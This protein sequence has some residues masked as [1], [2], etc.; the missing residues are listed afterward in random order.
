MK[1]LNLIILSFLAVFILND[2]LAQT[3]STF[4]FAVPY[5]TPDHVGET[6]GVIRLT[7]IDRE[8]EVTVT[9]PTSGSVIYQGVIPPGQTKSIVLPT[10]Y[11]QNNLTNRFWDV[12][13]SSSI[14]IRAKSPTGDM[15]PEIKAY[16]EIARVD[17]SDTTVYSN[18]NNNPDIFSLKGKNALGDEFYVPFQTYW[19]NNDFSSPGGAYS[20]FLMVA[21]EDNTT[22]TVNSPYP[23][24]RNALNGGGNYPA[25]TNVTITLDRGES[26]KLT[27]QRESAGSDII[28]IDADHRLRGTHITSDKPIAVTTGDDSDRKEGAYDFV[29]DQL[30]PLENIENEPVI[31]YEY[32]VMR[33]QVD[34]DNGG[35]RFY[36]LATEDNTSFDVDIDAGGST[37]YNIPNAGEQQVVDVP[38][39]SEYAHVIADKPVYVFHVSGFG[40]EIGGAVLPTIDGC[41]GSLDVSFV[42]SKEGANGDEFYLN[43]MTKKEGIANFHVETGNGDTT[44]TLD[45]GNFSHVPGTDWYI[46]DQTDDNLFTDAEITPHTVTRVY[47]DSSVF[48]L[49]MINGRT[50]GGGCMYGYFSDYIDAEP[51]VVIVSTGSTIKSGCFGDTIQ[52]RATG[53]ISY[54]WE[55]SDYLDDPTIAEPRA[56]GLPPGL[57][58]YDAIINNPCFGIDTLSVLIEIYDNVDAHFEIN[59]GIGCAPFD[60]TINNK[61]TG[62]NE[63]KW[64]WEDDRDFDFTTNSDSTFVHSYRNRGASDSVFT[65]RLVALNDSTICID[66]YQR[67]VRVHP[68]IH[69][70]FDQ[71]TTVGCNP[72]EVSFTDTSRGNTHPD[73]YEWD[74]GDGA[75][76]SSDTTL[77][78]TFLNNRNTDTTFHVQLVT[79][80]P[81]LCRD[82]A[83]QDITV[84]SYLEANFT[85]D[86]IKGCS[87]LEVN[88]NHNSKGDVDSAFWSFTGTSGMSFNDTTYSRKASPPLTYFYDTASTQTDT[89]DIRLRVSNGHCYD[90]ITRRVYVYPEVTAAYSP[91]DVAGC[92]PLPVS[93]TNQS[94]YTGMATSDTAGLVYDWDFGDGGASSRYEPAHLFDNSN[95]ADT[96]YQVQLTVTS[97]HGCQDSTSSQI[98]VS[99]YVKADFKVEETNGCAPFEVAFENTS[100]GG[101]DSVYWDFDEDG[102]ADSTLTDPYFT[103]TFSN[104]GITPDT[105]RLRQIVENEDNCRDTVYRNIIVY[106]HVAADF[107]PLDTLACNPAE[108]AFRNQSEYVGT[109]DTTG[110]LYDWDFGDGSTSSLYEPQY[111]FAHTGDTTAVFPVSLRVANAYGCADTLVDRVRVHPFVEAD[112]TLSTGAG[113]SPL[114]VEVNNYSSGGNYR[115]FWDDHHIPAAD[116]TG[117]SSGFSK[118]FTNTDGTIDTLQLT[119]IAGNALGCTDTMKRRVVI[120]PEVTA[121]FSPMDALGCNP[122]EQT[123]DNL[124]AY[125]NTNDNNGL[126]YHWDFGD[127]LSTKDFEPTHTYLNTADT[128]ARFLTRLQTISPYNCRDTITDTVEVHPFIQADFEVDKNSGCSPLNISIT[129]NSTGG[130]TQYYW[131]WDHD[132]SLALADADSVTT[133]SGFPITYTNTSGSSQENNLTLV[134]SN[135]HCY[136]T[137]QRKITV[138]SSLNAHFTEDVTQGCNPLTVDFD[139]NNPTAGA[140]SWE[141]GD[142]A[143]S[144]REDPTHEFTNP[145]VHDTIY[146]VRYIASTPYGC[147]DTA[148]Q[149][150]TVYSNLRAD[151]E[152]A[153]DE[154]CPPYDVTFDN[155]SAGNL[156][157]TYQWSVDGAP[158]GGAP[159]DTSDFSHTFTNQDPTLRY[160]EVELRAENIQGCTSIY[161]DTITVYQD[162]DADFGMSRVEGCSPLQIGFSD[163]ASVPANTTY[164]WS[165]GDGATSSARQPS[166]TFTNYDRVNDTSYTINL[167]VISP[168]NCHHD[169]S[170]SINVYHQP[171]ARFDIDT[172]ASCPPLVATMENQS[173]G[174][175][176]FQWRFGDG[177][178]NT[179]D[180]VVTDYSYGGNNTNSVKNYNLGLYVES[181]RGCGDST[182]L[183]LNVYPEVIADFTMDNAA[184]CHPHPVA[185]T[186]NSQNADH[187]LWDFDDGSSSNQEDPI[188]R[189]VN[190]SGSDTAYDV[191]LISSSAFQCR[192]T[193]T[194]TVEVYAQP[195]AQF[196]A[197]PQLQKWPEN[198][199]FITNATNTGPWDYQWNFDDGQKDD[200]RSPNYHDY[201]MWGPYTIGLEVQ[202]STSHCMDTISK[203][204][205]LLPPRTYANFAMD[206]PD[207]C[208]PHEVSFTGGESPFANQTTETYEYSWD[209]GDGT[210]GEGRFPNH[211]YDSAGT[212]YVSMK[213]TGAGGSD[214]ATDTIQVYKVPEVDF[215]VDPKLV[216]L[217]DQVMH[218]FN[219]TDYAE[220]Y[221]WN[222]GDGSTSEKKNPEHVYEELGTYDVVLTAYKEYKGQDGVIHTCADSLSKEDLVQVEGKGFIKFPDAFTPNK[223]GPSEGYWD[224]ED[225]SNDIFHPVGEG[226]VEY[227]LEIF[228]KWGERL[229][230]SEDFRVGWDGYFEGE[231]MPQDVYIYKA[232]GKYSNGSTFEKM[233]NVTL[234]R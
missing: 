29:G 119:L 189:F 152:I 157:N 187:Y 130:I 173:I 78:H 156:N 168:Y 192:D 61:T 228:N 98:T 230:I 104:G 114:E 85:V 81:E 202:S 3:D 182:S 27:P 47:N 169:T 36:V 204:V 136:D 79:T 195:N 26:Y 183:I 177:N 126:T 62:A 180:D 53:G 179:T 216:M 165:F 15:P 5:A 151:F 106:P 134:V 18:N 91:G 154:G 193:L 71:S 206:D 42:R 95:P 122:F 227:Q 120:Y 7:T 191:Q 31:G 185:F 6:G 103:R 97:P 176:S 199:V 198:R 38:V 49:G 161:R 142:G 63:Y 90:T 1:K 223:S 128:A 56:I 58:K 72:L 186:D 20:S 34:G 94:R 44:Y 197:N 205:Q 135:G 80:S 178:T 234:L 54:H 153:D 23:M 220:N 89:V 35:E 127:G 10:T 200:A 88:I 194:R 109:G 167:E 74:L 232:E 100:E 175:N 16:Y 4:W 149:N 146:Q 138:H 131:F 112:F 214:V 203:H 39:G 121:D 174:H 102:N 13:D 60:V 124:S 46:L 43:L 166:H 17:D 125:S 196:T 52:L 226:V 170:K 82:T 171:R 41:T 2:S 113:C 143:T 50:T 57:Y 33:G 133:S 218:C 111:A 190:T 28:S 32:L 92:N 67:Q 147:S 158:V 213:A 11:V 129:D 201:D 75:S 19:N 101:V 145:A 59:S 215:D 140:F 37:T 9:R 51:G 148:S 163:Q 211:V 116:T 25:N 209:F 77:N 229:F 222:F 233:G 14:L 76:S 207:G 150:I 84:R 66:E 164:S 45:P 8:A 64:D 108:V 172:T 224:P 93:F 144:N 69:A 70:G 123:F 132:P 73:G 162:V 30:V 137:L 99:P 188:H 212:Y 105:V 107:Q 24:A 65:M 68:E 87:P 159:T 115:W 48:H 117:F 83:R 219:F 96:A 225:T 141:F 40:D 231:L 118:T 12:R 110:L 21:T 217:P 184:D 155:T 55:P 208:E 160:Y 86:T 181:N 22:I 210:T 139:G 221:H